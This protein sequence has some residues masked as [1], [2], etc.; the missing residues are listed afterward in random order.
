MKVLSKNLKLGEMNL[1]V[2]SSDDLWHLYSV[3][4]KNDRVRAKTSRKIKIG[5]EGDSVKKT[6]ALT[7]S[8]EK[9]ELSGD[10]LR[11]SGLV[12]DGPED[13]P[14]QSHHSISLC[15]GDSVQIA[16]S[17]WLDFELKRIESAVNEL[18]TNF[19]LVVFDRE[20]AVF[21]LM[22]ASSYH[23]LSKIH[24]DVAKKRV[25]SKIQGNFFDVI[26]KQI[27]SY[28]ERYSFDAVVIGSP[29]FWKTELSKF[30]SD[31]KLK[32]K[33]FFAVV[34]GADES[35]LYEL[36]KREEV[37][38]ILSKQRAHF[39][40][41]LVNDVLKEIAK[42]G[43]VAYGRTEVDLAVNSGAVLSLL[44]TDSLIS[45]FKEDNSYSFLENL[46]RLTEKNS[47]KI[48]IVSSKH[49]GGSKL[50]GLGGIAALLRFR[51]N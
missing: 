47:G 2:E 20:D 50:D 30:I 18:K 14:R 29:S 41:L 34:S 12:I 23:I 17:S 8:V 36:L 48:V 51:L 15:Q 43:L 31:S 42:G 27:K 26:V 9:A 10:T 35:S 49:E 24:G 21:A 45:S 39:E 38:S 19:L 1:L 13:V 4:G 33:V 40:I 11:V 22:R 5:E 28:D 37:K 25:Q 7:L 46:F 44:V 3:I 32:K 16:K 6:M